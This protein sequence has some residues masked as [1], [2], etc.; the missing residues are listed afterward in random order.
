M[1]RQRGEERPETIVEIAQQRRMAAP[2]L[3]V[4]I[5]PAAPDVDHT[6][7]EVGVHQPGRHGQLAGDLAAGDGGCE[8]RLQAGGQIELLAHRAGKGIV[9]GTSPPDVVAICRT[10]S[11]RRRRSAL[12]STPKPSPLGDTPTARRSAPTMCNGT[13]RSIDAAAR[14]AVVAGRRSSHRPIHPVPGVVGTNDP[15]IQMPIERKCE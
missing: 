2:L 4:V 11:K 6:E 7:P 9:P 8:D 1:R 5:E 12:V 15:A 14:S 10:Q 13:D 3:L